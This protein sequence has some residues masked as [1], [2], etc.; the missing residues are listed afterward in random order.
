M[1]ST[2]FVDDLNRYMLRPSLLA[3]SGPAIESAPSL[4]AARRLGGQP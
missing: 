4:N 2:E 1:Q 3:P